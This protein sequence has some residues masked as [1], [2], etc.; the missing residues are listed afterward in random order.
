[1]NAAFEGSTETGHATYPGRTTT[2]GSSNVLIN[3]RKAHRKGDTWGPHTNTV[4]PYDTHPGETA[5]GSSSVFINGQP[6]ARVGDPI[7]CGGSI[8]TG[9]PNVIIGG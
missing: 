5:A 3:G 8:A 1:M 2:A 6:A 7:T 9:S 4:P